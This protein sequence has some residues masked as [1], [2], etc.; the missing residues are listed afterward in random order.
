[1]YYGLTHTDEIGEIKYFRDDIFLSSSIDGSLS[2]Y[3]I[4]Q[5]EIIGTLNLEGS[6]QS[7]AYNHTLNNLIVLVSDSY[8]YF[9][10]HG[11]IYPKSS[12][13][14]NGENSA[15]TGQGVEVNLNFE[16]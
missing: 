16:I 12:R 6:I 11:E 10:T 2:F 3:S 1:M 8:F 5:N 4:S 14:K 15:L 13:P 7:V 9:L